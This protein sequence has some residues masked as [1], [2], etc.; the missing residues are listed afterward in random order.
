MAFRGK[1][2][3]IGEITD[4]SVAFR[5]KMS[6][7]GKITDISVAFPSENVRNWGDYGHFGG[8]SD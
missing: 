8:F 6:V 7:I 5:G 1:M 2:S 3:V 4:I